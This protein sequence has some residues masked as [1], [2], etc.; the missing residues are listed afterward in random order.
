MSPLILRTSQE[1]APYVDTDKLVRPGGVEFLYVDGG[2]AEQ[3]TRG[4]RKQGA[5]CV[6]LP[7][8]DNLLRAIEPHVLLRVVGL[9][10]DASYA[11]S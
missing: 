10:S 11:T 2:D 9:V 4:E 5:A 6:I 8:S 7:L 3:E 1:V